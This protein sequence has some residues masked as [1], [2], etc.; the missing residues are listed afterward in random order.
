MTLRNRRNGLTLCVT[1]LPDQK[2]PS[3]LIGDELGFAKVAIFLNDGAADDFVAH[4]EK[5]VPVE[6]ADDGETD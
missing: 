3:L 2:K 4:L 1:T 6:E 5:M